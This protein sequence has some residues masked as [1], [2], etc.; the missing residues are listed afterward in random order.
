[1][2]HQTGIRNSPPVNERVDTRQTRFLQLVF[3]DET[4]RIHGMGFAEK[5]TRIQLQRE[6][7]HMRIAQN[8]IH[9]LSTFTHEGN[10]SKLT[11]RRAKRC[12]ENTYRIRH[13][14]F[15]SGSRPNHATR[16]LPNP[17]AIQLTQLGA[18]RP[19]LTYRKLNTNARGD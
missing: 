7:N 1:M 4:G 9:Q 12:Q 17:T 6:R 15:H 18:V 14:T 11:H 10:L 8:P 3:S 5:G 16:I 2:K 19:W 13:T